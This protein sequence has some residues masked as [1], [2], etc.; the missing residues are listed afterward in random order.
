ML[1]QEVTERSSVKHPVRVCAPAFAG[2]DRELAALTDALRDRPAV[3]LVEGEAGIGKSRLIREY[4]ASPEGRT[5]H[6]LLACCPPFRQPHT[7][8][9]VADAFRQAAPDGVRRLGLSALAGALRPLFPEW[10]DGLPPALEPAEDATAARHRVFRGLAELAGL[11]RVGT[12]VV[13]DVH[14]ADEVTVEFLLY[15]ASAQPPPASLILT[16]RPE[17]VQPG[18]LLPR[19]SRLAVGSGGLRLTVGPLDVIQTAGLVS[20]ML[21]REPVS[22]EFAVFLHQ[23]T[24]GIPLAVEELVQ[25]LASHA[26]LAHRARGGMRRPLTEMAVP[27]TIRDAVLE[28]AGR[29]P[30]D[31]QA[32]LRAAAV[33][34]DPSAE[35][36]EYAVAGI[37]VERA[38]SG[39]SQ[40]LG[41][42][43]LGEDGDGRVS[44][45]HALAARAVYEAIL[46]PERR[47]LHLRAGEALEA[48]R[49]LPAARLSWHFREA[50]DIA[51]W[52]RY[53]EQAADLA[54][55]VGDEVHAGS[56]LCDLVIRAGLPPAEMTRL[57]DKIQLFT[58]GRGQ[59]QDLAEVLRTL[60]DDEALAP[61]QKAEAR[62]QFGWV[63]NVLEEF[64]ASRAE[65]A[66]AV[67]G[68][69]TGSS[70]ML[71]A[72]RLLGFPLGTIRSAA[73]YLRWLRRAAQMVPP[74]AVERLSFA[75]FRAS[76]LLILG[77]QEGWA[78]AAVIPGE[79]SSSR[80]RAAVTT[81]HG[82]I[83][84]AA[85]LWGH[86]GEASNR[87]TRAAGLAG[88]Y[89][90]PRLRTNA[91]A[92]QAHL[93]WFTGAWKGLAGRAAAL[94]GDEELELVTRLRVLLVTGLL[95]GAQGPRADAQ[96]Q[97]EQ[98]LGEARDHGAV[99][100]LAEPAAALARLAL[101]D[102]DAG[103]A[104]KVTDE[105]AEIVSCKGTW[106][107]ATDLAPA[108]A[109]ALTAAGR[110]DD[111]TELVAA[112]ARGLRGRD[113]PAPK[114]GLALCRAILAGARGE[115][116]RAAVLF[117]RAAAAWQ[118]LPRPYDA[119]LAR[120]RQARCLLAASRCEQGLGLL[121]EVLQGLSGLGA[122]DAAQRVQRC[123]C[124]NGV[125]VWRGWR[126]GRRGYGNQLSP[127]E[128]EVVRLAAA[129]LT[130]REIAGQ[131][132]RS[133]DTVYTQVRAAMRKLGVSSRTALAL[134]A[135]EA[136]LA[137]DGEPPGGL[138]E[139]A[140]GR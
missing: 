136:G 93:D 72:V 56:L 32:V 64:E 52:A 66:R 49:P 102:G 1:V 17:D 128:L 37:P 43:L 22:G 8:A 99:D 65:T 133:P 139:S 105:P 45:R 62:F 81:G 19:L 3:V 15:L 92:L 33:L 82:N 122:S 57:A 73:E 53:A 110:V 116:A 135:A 35:A 58:L 119:L 83:G 27:P 41:C 25:L 86:Y 61:R 38:R 74:D 18:S 87:L 131:L 71:R 11:L 138:E 134:R 75:N 132:Y 14:W 51:R 24:E 60:A 126:G 140:A 90:Y 5:Q 68:L 121:A 106:V 4:L 20:S 117:A 40:A 9:P 47:A 97:L 96:A 26:D 7:L 21:G 12:L 48:A 42:G 30:A 59:L 127:R 114:A 118:A 108:R 91:V 123:L 67:P 95:N 88:R 77:Q 39:L 16:C 76:A 36:T 101:A 100:Y 94:A 10:A 13:E 84:E 112:F 113:A 130:N 109:G 29:L 63:L 104:L 103:M 54:L 2:R 46:I 111:A 23:Q 34:T 79:P 107:W 31:A 129:G 28:R 98:V 85:L 6:A 55:A 50:G 78:A 120:E 115:H 70:Q 125:Q 44:F 124:E 69:P 89:E 80:E 137:A